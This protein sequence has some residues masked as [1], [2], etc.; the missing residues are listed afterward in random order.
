M[1]AVSSFV[2]PD[3]INLNITQGSDFNIGFV[4]ADDFGKAMD[5]TNYSIGGYVKHRF[6]DAVPLFELSPSIANT[7]SG[8]IQISLPPSKTSSF[9]AGEHLYEIE[10]ISGSS[11]GVKIL[12]GFCNVFPEV[13]K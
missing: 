13:N 3:K 12:N 1:V 10:L 11:I 2:M 8:L 9:P 4:A 6:G 7:V 5:L